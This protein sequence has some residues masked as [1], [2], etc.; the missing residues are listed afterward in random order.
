M[1]DI[2]LQIIW[3]LFRINEATAFRKS[4]D[5]FIISMDNLFPAIL[6][7]YSWDVRHR[8]CLIKIS[9]KE[10]KKPRWCVFWIFPNFDWRDFG[11]FNHNLLKISI[12]FIEVSNQIDDSCIN[13][14]FWS[15]NSLEISCHNFDNSFFWQLVHPTYSYRMLKCFEV[16]FIFLFSF[17]CNLSV[18]LYLPNS[19]LPELIYLSAFLS[20]HFVFHWAHSSAS[21][22]LFQYFLVIIAFYTIVFDSF[23]LPLLIT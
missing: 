5:E 17:S 21:L 18:S 20:S 15:V 16:F 19:I 2:D 3:Q 1:P 14:A 22:F 6:F 7:G 12:F 9:L 11:F 13:D 8:D 4:L 10:L 23:F